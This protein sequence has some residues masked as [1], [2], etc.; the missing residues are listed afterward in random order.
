MRAEISFGSPG[1]WY[2][3]SALSST[4]RRRAVSSAQPTTTGNA[5][6]VRQL[7]AGAQQRRIAGGE[8]QCAHAG[9][10]ERRSELQQ[11]ARLGAPAVQEGHRVANRGDVGVGQKERLAHAPRAAS[12]W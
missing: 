2:H 6:S 4:A 3:S 12:T 5:A 8:Q 11:G 9:L 10:T 7:D 1:S